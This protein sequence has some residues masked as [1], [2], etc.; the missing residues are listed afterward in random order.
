LTLADFLGE[1]GVAL[2]AAQIVIGF[3]LEQNSGVLGIGFD[4]NTGAIHRLRNYFQF[5]VG[6]CNPPSSFFKQ[7]HN[8]VPFIQPQVCSI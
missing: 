6:H 5:Y 2:A 8:L 3:T 1:N 4:Y 7:F